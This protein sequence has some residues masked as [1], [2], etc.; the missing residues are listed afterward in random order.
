[1]SYLRLIQQTMWISTKPRVALISVRLVYTQSYT[2]WI[3]RNISARKADTVCG[4]FGCLPTLV[5]ELYFNPLLLTCL[6]LAQVCE[7]MDKLIN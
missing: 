5:S 1:M 7:C 4:Y 3:S 6:K 2:K